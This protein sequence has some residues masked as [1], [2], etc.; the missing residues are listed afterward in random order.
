MVDYCV[1]RNWSLES[2]NVW[3][4][5]GQLSVYQF[6]KKLSSIR[7]ALSVRICDC[8]T[9]QAMLLT[10]SPTNWIKTA[11]MDR[12]PHRCSFYCPIDLIC[13]LEGCHNWWQLCLF[14]NH[15]TTSVRSPVTT[16]TSVH[17]AEVLKS[18]PG[19]FRFKFRHADKLF[20]SVNFR[21]FPQSIQS[22][23]SDYFM[24]DLL[25]IHSN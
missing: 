1:H 14:I 18:F 8:I 23:T 4:F 9:L 3:E 25:Y 21:C 7:H 13:E 5:P 20:L 10:K 16:L 6:L 2:I 11:S 24:V 19:G 12:A 22:S 15:H 17:W